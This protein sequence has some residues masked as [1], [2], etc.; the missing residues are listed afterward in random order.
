MTLQAYVMKLGLFYDN[1]GNVKKAFETFVYSYITRFQSCYNGTVNR[2]CGALF[3]FSDLADF[4]AN[5]L[6]S[7]LL[8]RNNRE[9]AR[10]ELRLR[11]WRADLW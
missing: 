8:A 5:N 9:R 10:E 6:S 4:S 1:Q 3:V 2:T 11:V 7:S